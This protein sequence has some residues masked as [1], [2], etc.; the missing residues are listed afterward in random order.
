MGPVLTK[1]RVV[2]V[3][4]EPMLRDALREFLVEEGVD[5]VG[6]AADGREGVNQTLALGPDVVLMDLRMPILDG[7]DATSAI[8]E[9]RPDIHVIVLTAYEDAS[10]QERA[11]EAGADAYVVK[12]TSVTTM[13]D[14][15]LGFTKR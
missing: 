7:I 9:Q 12:G 15:I 1:P 2:L 4:D 3:D 6:E 11:K 10:L 13:L 8:K 5:V 14:M